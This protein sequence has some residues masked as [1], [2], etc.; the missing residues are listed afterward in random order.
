MA[1]VYREWRA[2]DKL[3]AV[4]TIQEAARNDYNLSPSRYVATNDVE[5]VLPLEE[6]VLLLA[7]AEEQRG[8]ADAQLQAVLTQLGLA[9]DLGV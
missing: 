7:Q 1:D 4:V 8:E 2:E 5:E 9:K 3:S 6:A